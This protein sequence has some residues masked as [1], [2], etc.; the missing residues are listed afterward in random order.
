VLGRQLVLD[1]VPYEIIGVMPAGFAYPSPEAS[2]WIPMR[3]DP[4]AA[5][6]YWGV[7]ACSTIARLHDGVTPQAAVSELRGWTPRVQAM[8]PADAGLVGRGHRIGAD[9]R[10]QVAGARVRSLLMMGAVALVLLIGECSE[11]HDCQGGF[12][13]SHDS[14][15]LS[16]P[17]FQQIGEHHHVIFRRFRWNSGYRIHKTG[18]RAGRSGAPRL[19]SRSYRRILSHAPNLAPPSGRLFRPEDDLRGFARLPP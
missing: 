9:A 1:D 11:P 10:A 4:R 12:G 17:L 19:H 8:F 14:D 5:G 7:N 6:D 15:N 2:F 3:L 13:G 18:Y 16:H